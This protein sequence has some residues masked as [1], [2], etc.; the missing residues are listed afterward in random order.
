MDT[1]LNIANVFAALP[2]IFASFRATDVLDFL[3]VIFLLYGILIL[4]KR[5]HS[6]FIFGGML[7]LLGIYL[8]ARILNLYL[9]SLIFQAF[10]GFFAVIFV[11]IFQRELRNFFEWLTVWGRM[12]GRRRESISEFVSGQIIRAVRQMAETKIGALIVLAGD[13]PLERLIE[14]GTLLDGRISYPLLISIFDPSSPGHDG[15][16]IV[17]GSRIKKFGAHLPLAE[18]FSQFETR[19]T[20]HRAAMGLVERA[21]ALVIVVSEER[22]KVSIAYRGELRELEN[23]E[24]LQDEITKFY[25]EEFFHVGESF[26]WNIIM[27]NWREKVLAV[28]IAAFLWFVFVVQLGTGVVTKQYD[29]PVELH[30]L[31]EGYAVEQM[32]SKA[33][34]VT[35]SGRRQEFNLL[36]EG[37]MKVVIAPENFSEE[38]QRV[39][40]N[41]EMIAVPST[42][43]IVSFTP[44]NIQFRLKKI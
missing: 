11:V 26:W 7:V 19:G 27:E 17:E 31:P 1:L 23:I 9:T 18:K 43:D 29:I 28:A 16:V 38:S 20:R 35:V 12:S 36:N 41:E 10:F 25:K 44:K 2:D 5:A 13:D 30:S 14:G 39:R 3:I 15:A 33:V 6:F 42:L 37:S 40:V 24:T 4:L 8:A 22:G 32:S 34:S 21:D